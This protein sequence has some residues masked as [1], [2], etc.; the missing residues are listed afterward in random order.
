M[1]SSLYEL[2]RIKNDFP[3]FNNFLLLFPVEIKKNVKIWRKKKEI[4]VTPESRGI[5]NTCSY[6]QF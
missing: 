2:I 1:K 5:K 4:T 6:K 3:Y